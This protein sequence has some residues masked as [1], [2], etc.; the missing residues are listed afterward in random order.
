VLA[1][2]AN[3]EGQYGLHWAGPFDRA[4]ASRQTSAVEVLTAAAAVTAQG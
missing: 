4:D 2:D 1:S 3:E